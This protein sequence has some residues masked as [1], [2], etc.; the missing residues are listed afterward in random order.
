MTY[1]ITHPTTTCAF[2]LVI[3]FEDVHDGSDI[4]DICCINTTASLGTAPHR[5]AMHRTAFHARHFTH[6]IT[7]S[8]F[9][10]RSCSTENT[11]FASSDTT[12][13]ALITN[14]FLRFSG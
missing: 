7:A 11:T 3:R 2:A 12:R 10:V 8:L 1:L 14:A 4:H 5:T 13:G 9:L 6:R